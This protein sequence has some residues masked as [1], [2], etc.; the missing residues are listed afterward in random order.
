MTKKKVETSQVGGELTLTTIF[1]T[2]HKEWKKFNNY[3]IIKFI[4]P[5]NAKKKYWLGK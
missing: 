4:E 5:N 3:F 1:E 2:D